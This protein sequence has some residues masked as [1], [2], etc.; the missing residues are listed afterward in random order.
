M[1]V[2]GLDQENV[3]HFVGRT[4]FPSL[5]IVSDS[6]MLLSTSIALQSLKADLGDSLIESFALGSSEF[7]LLFGG[8]AGPVAVL[9]QYQFMISRGSRMETH[10]ESTS[11]PRTATTDL[12][13][14]AKKVECSLVAKRNIDDAVVGE[15]AHGSK[16]SAFLSSPLSPGAHKNSSILAPISTTLP[17]L[18]GAVPESSPLGWEV[19]VTSRNPNEESIILLKDGRICDLRDRRV[20]WRS[21]HFC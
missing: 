9:S 8:L 11:A 14:I 6:S 18:P 15:G 16:S 17:L 21:M 5:R 10:R 3:C 4:S 2:V 19:A 13:V 7:K 12:A 1:L 20:F